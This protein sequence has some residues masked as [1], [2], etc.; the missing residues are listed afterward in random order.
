MPSADL[1]LESGHTSFK[2]GLGGTDFENFDR[3]GRRD[4]GRRRRELSDHE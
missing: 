1:I 2:F 3:G 4:V